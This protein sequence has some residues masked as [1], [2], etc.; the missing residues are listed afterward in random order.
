[1]GQVAGVKPALP[2]SP[3]RLIGLLPISR[4]YTLASDWKLTDFTGRN[5]AS[6]LTSFPEPIL[7][8][9]HPECRRIQ[10]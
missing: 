10:C 1:M 4:E 8:Q 3:G 5:I 2:Y 7:Q 6:L 9:P